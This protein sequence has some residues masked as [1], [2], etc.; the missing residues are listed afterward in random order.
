MMNR[1]KA[2]EN[3][4]GSMET[5]GYIFDEEEKALLEKIKNGELPLSALSDLAY[6]RVEQLRKD[7]PEIFVPEDK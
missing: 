6:K 4:V 2:V 7:R 5:E 3:A 1:R